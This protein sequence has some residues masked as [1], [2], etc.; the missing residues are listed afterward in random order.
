MLVAGFD[1]LGFDADDVAVFLDEADAAG[2]IEDDG[3]VIDGGAGEMDGEA[4]VVELAI[5]IDDAAIEAF[6]FERGEE[7]DH[8]LA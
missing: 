5:V 2:V 8:F 6:G 4:G 3:T 7:G 1:A